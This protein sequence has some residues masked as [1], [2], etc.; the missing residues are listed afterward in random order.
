MSSQGSSSVRTIPGTA[1]VPKLGDP[2]SREVSKPSISSTESAPEVAS[3]PVAKGSLEPSQKA[4]ST[5]G[6]QSEEDAEEVMVNCGNLQSLIM[7]E[8]CTW[9]SLEYGLE[10]VE[11]DDTERPHTPL[12]GYVALSEHY[13]R[14][15]VRFPLNPFFVEVLKYFGLT[16]FQITPNR[17]VHMIGLFGLFAEH[18]MGPPTI[19]E[20]VWF[21]SVMSNKNDGGFYYFV[22]RPVKGLHAIVKIND[23]LGPW[24]ESYFFTPEVQVRGTFGR[25][26]K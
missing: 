7:P 21:Y 2:L 19:E 11:P 25:A 8:D 3:R 5:S 1:F 4:V 16:V 13:L 26:R 6:H 15:R 12:V 9:I 23:N 17:W 20:F 14:F 22:K 10:V 24:K 18:G